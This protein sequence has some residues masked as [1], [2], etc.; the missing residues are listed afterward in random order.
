LYQ[1]LFSSVARACVAL[2]TLVDSP[3]GGRFAA[4]AAA[5]TEAPR[6]LVSQSPEAVVFQSSP[7][8][9]ADVQLP[10][11]TLLVLLPSAAPGLRLLGPILLTPPSVLLGVPAVPLTWLAI[12]ATSML[13]P[14]EAST[15]TEGAPA[16]APEVLTATAGV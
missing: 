5:P 14:F 4:E 13:P 10:T 6:S 7:P 2:L 8:E 11:D 9:C 12:D 1:P 3:E 15:G 16:A